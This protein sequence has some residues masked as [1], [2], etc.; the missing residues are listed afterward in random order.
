MK[1]AT[2]LLTLALT[3]ACVEMTDEGAGEIETSEAAAIVVPTTVN[4]KLFPQAGV[5]GTQRINFAVPLPQGALAD[6]TKVR[7]RRNGAEIAAVVRALAYWPDGSFRSVQIQTNVD[8]GSTPSLD[9][10]VGTAATKPE[11]T[12]V[13]VWTTLMSSDG[14]TGPKVWAQLPASWLADSGVVG[15]MIPRA[16]IASTALDAWQGVCDH[17]KWDTSKFLAAQSDKG[18]WLYDR[19]TA[20]YRGYAYTGALSPMQSA[21]KEAAIYRAGITGTNS[22]TRIGVPGSANDLKYHYAQG[23]AI[24]YLM[25]G[26]PRF[27]E[28][29]ENVAVR[30]H[31]LWGDPG[32]EGA[33]DFWTERH[34]GF[35]LLAYEWA[36]LVSDDRAKTFRGWSDTAVTAYLAMQQA[37]ASPSTDARCFAHHADAHGEDFGYVGCSP[38]MSAI[39]ADGLDAYARRAGGTK[40]ANAR[41]GIV[42]LGRMIARH[43]RDGTGKPYY[44]QGAGVS[45]NE[46]DAY[47]EHWGESAYVVAMAWHHQ[48]RTDAQLRTAADQLVAGTKSKG[49]TGQLRSFNWQCRSAV[50]TPA[51][52]K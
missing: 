3:G 21:Y 24:H 5:T 15:P 36:A 17:A 14:K 12:R 11:L 13:S 2:I 51:F 52:L 31:D 39:L 16:T 45:S 18:A 26:D 1:H 48:G 8:V 29:A 9:V 37:P 44:W 38:W 6:R 25:T 30:A 4:V 23:L 7:V 27:R 34:A 10:D 33:A 28:A 35:A 42:R 20:M 40:A 46:V 19:A 50:A 49:Y 47:H 43:G 22:S 32:Y 41:A